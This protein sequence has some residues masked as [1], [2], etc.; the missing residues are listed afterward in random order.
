MKGCSPTFIALSIVY[1]I[2]FNLLLLLLSACPIHRYSGGFSS[3]QSKSPY[4]GP[5]SLDFFKGKEGY[6]DFLLKTKAI[7]ENA[8]KLAVIPE[9][10]VQRNEFNSQYFLD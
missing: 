2:L 6:D 10:M 7:A 1:T 8:E 4:S 5:P 3:L 9:H